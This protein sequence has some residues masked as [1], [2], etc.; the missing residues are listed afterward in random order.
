MKYMKLVEFSEQRG[1]NIWKKKSM[2]LKQTIRRK[3]LE[4]YT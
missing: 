1:E 4:T 3:I 2:N